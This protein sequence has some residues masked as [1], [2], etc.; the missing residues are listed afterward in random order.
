MGRGVPLICDRNHA[1]AGLGGGIV[2][3]VGSGGPGRLK[4]GDAVMAVVVPKGSR[5]STAST[6]QKCQL[7]PSSAISPWE[8]S[9]PRLSDAGAGDQVPQHPLSFG[10]EVRGLTLGRQ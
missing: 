3:E 6:V 10:A 8:T 4:L 7:V 1:I 2:D 5:G 9:G